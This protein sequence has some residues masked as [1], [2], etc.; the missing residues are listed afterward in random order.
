[1]NERD[2]IVIALLRARTNWHNARLTETDYDKQVQAEHYEH[3]L[4][5]V[6]ALIQLMWPQP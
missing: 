6:L 4:D 1:M 3:C 5:Q 2:E